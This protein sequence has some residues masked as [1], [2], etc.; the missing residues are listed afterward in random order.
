MPLQIHAYTSLNAN[1]GAFVALAS[2]APNRR[3]FIAPN[4]SI[5]LANNVGGT[6]AIVLSG[7]S[8]ARYD[9]GVTNPSTLF[10][11]STSASTTQVSVYSYDPGES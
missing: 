1:S 4:T 9:L 8:A 6:G 7:G 10:A 5:S 11:R 2:S 3:L